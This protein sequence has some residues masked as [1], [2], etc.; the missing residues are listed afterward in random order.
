MAGVAI[1]V[2][3]AILGLAFRRFVLVKSSPDPKSWTS[4]VVALFILTL[5]LTYLNGIRETPFAPRVNWWVHALVILAFPYLIL[6]S[7]HFHI[8]LAPVAIFLRLPRLATTP[9]STSRR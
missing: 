7:K 2:S 8:I 4:A 1:L 9:R 3:L 5:M 6:K